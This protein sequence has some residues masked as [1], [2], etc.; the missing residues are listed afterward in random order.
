MVEESFM[1][2][3]GVV[4]GIMKTGI[5]GAGPENSF[6]VN[7]LSPFEGANNVM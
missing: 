7:I 6:G 2:I 5:E 1:A 3:T 4:A